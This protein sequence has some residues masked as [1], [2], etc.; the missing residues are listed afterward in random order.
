MNVIRSR[1]HEVFSEEVNKIAL[2]SEDDK[3]I[4]MEDGVHTKAYGHYSLRENNKKIVI[5][6]MSRKISVE[7]VVLPD[8]PLTNFEILSVVNKLGIPNFRGVFLRDV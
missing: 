3:R 8:K 5:Q 2:S 4:I 7:G 6:K 1:R